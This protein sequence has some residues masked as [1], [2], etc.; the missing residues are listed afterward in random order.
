MTLYLPKYTVVVPSALFYDLQSWTKLLGYFFYS[1][2]QLKTE[3]FTNSLVYWALSIF[4]K[5]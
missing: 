2:V 5:F 1:V 3:Q 4:G